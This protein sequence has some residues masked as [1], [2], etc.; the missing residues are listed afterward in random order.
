M[1]MRVS[2]TWPET[3]ATAASR[4]LT[5]RCRRRISGVAA[6]TVSAI[7]TNS[8]TTSIGS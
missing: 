2:A 4:S 5:S 3:R 1:F 7:I 8:P 6:A